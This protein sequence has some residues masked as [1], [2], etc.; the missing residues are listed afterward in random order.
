MAETR[1]MTSAGFADRDDV[2]NDYQE[3]LARGYILRRYANARGWTAAIWATARED[4]LHVQS[5][6]SPV[7]PELA[8]TILRRASSSDPMFET[9]QVMLMREIAIEVVRGGGL[10]PHD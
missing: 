1:D 7:D 8:W 4:S 3:L 10:D 5:T 2:S 9:A 6:I